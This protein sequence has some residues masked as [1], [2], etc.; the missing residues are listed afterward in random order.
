MTC[1]TRENRVDYELFDS[2]QLK[3]F[4]LSERSCLM[5]SMSV[6]ATLYHTRIQ[7]F[8]YGLSVEDWSYIEPDYNMIIESFKDVPLE[9]LDVLS[10]YYEA[11]NHFDWLPPKFYV[12]IGHV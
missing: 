8:T 4:L 6:I 7:V 9:Q 12:R 11:D 2:E 1:G 5:W 10:L 3:N